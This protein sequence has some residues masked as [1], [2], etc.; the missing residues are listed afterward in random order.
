MRQQW[1]HMRHV[2][3]KPSPAPDAEEDS[4]QRPSWEPATPTVEREWGKTIT[5][6]KRKV[7]TLTVAKEAAHFRTSLFPPSLLHIEADLKSKK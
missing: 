2:Q 5:S 3:S 1:T 4:D 7:S 6:M